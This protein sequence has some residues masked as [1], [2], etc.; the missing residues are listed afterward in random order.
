MSSEIDFLE[1]GN[2][3]DPWL[4]EY[5]LADPNRAIGDIIGSITSGEAITLP[6]RVYA[7]IGRT[8]VEGTI[9]QVEALF[10]DFCRVDK[11]DGLFGSDDPPQLEAR[12]VT[13]HPNSLDSDDGDKRPLTVVFRKNK[14]NEIN[15]GHFFLENFLENE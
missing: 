9:D 2:L 5:R 8:S 7:G 1:E 15:S 6:A 10:T 13:K 11:A 4:T 3:A 14:S 12:G